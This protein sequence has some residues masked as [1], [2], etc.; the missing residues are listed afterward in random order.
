MTHIVRSAVRNIDG[1]RTLILYFYDRKK[2]ATGCN[3]AEYALFQRKDD[4]ITLQH[5]EDGKVKWREA[6][7]DNLGDRYS[8]ISRTSAFYRRRDEQIVTRFC[9]IT[10]KSGLEALEAMQ[11]SIM[12]A[13]HKAKVLAR[14]R[15]TIERMKPVPAVPRR[16]RTWIHGDVLPHYIFYDYVRGSKAMNAYCTACQ[17]DVIVSGAKHNHEGNCPR[18]G[19]AVTFK[20]SGVA[21]N[22][23]DRDTV[24][25]LQKTAGNELILRIFKVS[26]NLRNWRRPDT[27]VWE[28]ARCFIRH[29]DPEKLHFEPYY[30]SY[31]KGTLTH[32]LKGI[33]PRFSH[34]Q[35]SFDGD[36]C[37]Y[38][39][40]A[41][42]ETALAD[43]PWQYSQIGRFHQL[44]NMPLEVLPYLSSYLEYP[45]IEYLVR[46]GLTRLAAQIIYKHDGAKAINASGT[47]L[48]ETLGI[49]PEDLSALQSVNADARQLELCRRLRQQG[50][51]VDEAL[52]AW[53]RERGIF[54]EVDVLVPLK[55]T[56]PQKLMRYIEEQFVRQAGEKSLRNDRLGQILSDFRDYLEMGGSLGYDFSDS[57]V[58][59]PRD[60]SEAHNQASALYDTR[61]N[62]IF[63]KA[64]R[65]A[66]KALAERYR[67]SK[68]GFTIIPPRTAGEIVAEGHALH[69]CVHS[70]VERVAEGGCVILFIRQ[71]GSIKEPFYTVELRGGKITQIHGLQHRAPTP[72]VMKFLETWER[73]KLAAA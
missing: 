8:Y 43:T 57:F 16:L 15:K 59:F 40:C 41:N 61:K 14:E 47:N 30:Y 20:A 23:W 62:A 42:L 18:C 7:L 73:K 66:Y 24:Q 2:A 13:R 64:I 45:A 34:Y 72:E 69:H 35:Y 21:K 33:R 5:T 19:K 56:T 29:D 11:T 71:R 10:E 51:R 25:V 6:S 22:V 3:V 65:E 54:S 48:R 53:Y 44:G 70:Y 27:S 31:N 55:Y 26:A 9:G 39:Y 52:L 58:L 60:L 32:W 38:L 50:V 36:T 1:R 68:D 63:D 4:Y 17:N 46:F 37:G 49:A 28:C 67:F 12:H